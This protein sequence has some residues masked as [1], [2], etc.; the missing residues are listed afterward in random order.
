MPP[1]PD[2]CSGGAVCSCGGT[3]YS[4]ECAAAGVGRDVDER[5]SCDTPDGFFVCGY[6]YCLK[7]FAYCEVRPSS[8]PSMPTGYACPTLPTGCNACTCMADSVDCGTSCTS[9]SSGD[10][11]VTCP[12]D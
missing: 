2:G 5:S 4:D 3:V 11:T 1:A 9:N 8:D 7:N 10:L 6:R 12:A